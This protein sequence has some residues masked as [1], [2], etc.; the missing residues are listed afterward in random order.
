MISIKTRE[1]L[2]FILVQALFTDDDAVRGP[3]ACRIWALQR[4]GRHNTGIPPNLHINLC[5][6]NVSA[7]LWSTE[8]AACPLS[9]QMYGHMHHRLAQKKRDLAIFWW[10]RQYFCLIIKQKG[11]WLVGMHRLMTSVDASRAKF[12]VSIQPTSGL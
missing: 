5:L 4:I 1:L 10:D 9:I 7:L 2:W 11:G 3:L 6:R 12:P 8:N